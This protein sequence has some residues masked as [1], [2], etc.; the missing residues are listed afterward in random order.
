MTEFIKNE[1]A[2][3]E[4]KKMELIGFVEKEH[5]PRHYFMGNVY[6]VIPGDN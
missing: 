4:D 2:I 6:K 3:F 5:V 1:I